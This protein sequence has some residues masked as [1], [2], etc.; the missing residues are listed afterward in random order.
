MPRIV[1]YGNILRCLD[2]T[3]ASFAPIGYYMSPPSAPAANAPSKPPAILPD[4]FELTLQALP[5]AVVVFDRRLQ[6]TLRN[7]AA[8]HLLPEGDELPAV[9]SAV[10][11]E[12]SYENWEAELRGVLDHQRPHSFD[13]TGRITRDQP[14]L[15]LH[16]A[17]NPLRDAD[18]SAV[19]GGVLIAEDVTGRI[20][21]E[22]RL[23]VSERL[24]AVGKLAARVA[25]ELNNPLDGILRFTNLALRKITEGASVDPK[26]AKYLEHSRA[27]IL[28]MRDIISSLL[29]F[30]RTAPNTFEQAT[31]NRIAEDAVTALEGRAQESGVSVVCKFHQTDMP[32]VRGTTLFQVFCNL[33]KNAIDAMSEGGTLVVTTQ[34]TADDLIATFEDTGIGLPENS[35]QIF[36]PFFTTKAPGK[37]TGLGLAV[38]RELIEKYGGTITARNRQPKGAMF[39]VTVPIRNLS[40]GHLNRS[41]L[42]TTAKAAAPSSNGGTHRE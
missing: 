33:I 10:A 9:L 19:T 37:G 4:V 17:V 23:A 26:I 18:T 5:C 38:C 28:R 34:M 30:S 41:A 12:S 32:V 15:F 14:E 16:V 3:P 29:E 7:E 8:R 27:G 6:I 39:V 20:G 36:E 11:I 24:A 40:A 2:A 13:I 31:I 1:R 25:H 21:M 35:E 22:R 42:P